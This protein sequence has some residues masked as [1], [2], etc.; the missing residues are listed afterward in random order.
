MA[1]RRRNNKWMI[2]IRYKT[3][4]GK[5]KRV[6]IV[7]PVNTRKGAEKYEREVRQ[8]LLDD[9]FGK[10]EKEEQ[11]EESRPLFKEFSERFMQK[12]VRTNNKPS[13]AMTKE[14]ILK[15]HLLPVF[16]HLTL[17][18]IG[19]EC[20]DDYR[21]KKLGEGKAAKTIYNHLAVLHKIL[22]VACDYEELERL[23]KFNWQRFPKPNFDF[24]D[25]DEAE[26]LVANTEARWRKMVQF[27]LN[28]GLRLGEL[29]E[30][31]GC[32]LSPSSTMVVVNRTVYRGIVGTPKSNRGR[33]VPLNAKAQA[34]LPRRKLKTNELVFKNHKGQQITEQSC[35]WPLWRAC[36]SAGIRRI[37]WHALRHTFASH[38]AMKGVPLRVVQE[39]LG[40]SSITMTERYAHLSPESRI[41][42]VK[43]LDG[44]KVGTIWAQENGELSNSPFSQ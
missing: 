24:L 44:N 36:D 14:S 38:L 5:S 29:R 9:N 30:L 16:G 32:D 8:S 13:E 23:P 1:V 31:R 34:V 28:T 20:I 41:D 10:T 33:K 17:D 19:T 18:Q 7:S 3:A 25:F 4:E 43:L 42:A 22:V 11:T 21:A 26:A 27:A 2:D 39:L 40:H 12:H 6:R 15:H 37:G 35:K